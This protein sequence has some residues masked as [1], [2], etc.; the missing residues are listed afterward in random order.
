MPLTPDPVTLTILPRATVHLRDHPRTRGPEPALD[1]LGAAGRPSTASSCRRSRRPTKSG[2]TPLIKHL[3]SVRAAGLTA[4]HASAVAAAGGARGAPVT[5]AVAVLL[6]RRLAR[7]T[8]PRFTDVPTRTRPSVSR[9]RRPTVCAAIHHADEG[10]PWRLALIL[11]LHLARLFSV[12]LGVADAATYRALAL[13]TDPGWCS[14]GR[15]G[16]L[17]PAVPVHQ[18]LPAT[19]TPACRLLW[20]SWRWSAR[21]IVAPPEP[22]YSRK[23]FGSAWRLAAWLGP[24]AAV[25]VECAALVALTGMTVAVLPGARAVGGR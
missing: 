2:T 21:L 14:S 19:T 24:G 5:P 17:H 18:R 6:P 23:A 22:R 16:R 11:A 8:S 10:W 25:E 4:Q 3:A 12:L 13:I 1:G 7:T 9:T 20:C 15:R